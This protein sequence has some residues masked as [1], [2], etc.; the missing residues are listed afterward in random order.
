MKS[1]NARV[2]AALALTITTVAKSSTPL[3]VDVNTENLIFT[4]WSVPHSERA[5]EKLELLTSV[6]GVDPEFQSFSLTVGEGHGWNLH[7]R[8]IN[9]LNRA[10][11]GQGRL[12]ADV[13]VQF[14]PETQ[15]ETATLDFGNVTLTSQ[16]YVFTVPPISPPI[17]R[18]ELCIRWCILHTI[19]DPS[20]CIQRR[21]G[22]EQ[23]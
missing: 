4:S 21:C 8:R 23:N 14:N 20:H 5:R 10:S 11:I 17:N 3:L 7:D 22:G 18:H 19:D 12:L 15:I 16:R 13:D 2:L 6:D 9:L 1:T